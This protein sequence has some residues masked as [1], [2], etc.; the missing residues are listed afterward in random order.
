MHDSRIKSVETVTDEHGRKILRLT[1]DVDC[2]LLPK[3]QPTNDD[4]LQEEVHKLSKA[5]WEGCQSIQEVFD[6]R[7]LQ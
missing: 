1:L 7:R 6:K 3:V 5:F 2:D 4:E